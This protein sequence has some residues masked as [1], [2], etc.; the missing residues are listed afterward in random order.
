M[1]D[2]M[3]TYDASGNT[4]WDG[5]NYYWYDA[6]G[7]LCAVQSDRLN[8]LG[9]P[10]QYLYD[11]EGARIGKATLA[12]APA[13]GATCAPPQA[14][15]STLSFG[16]GSVFNTRWLV[17]LCGRQVTELTETPTTETWAHSNIFLG[18]AL[19][20]TYDYNNG[21]GGLHLTMLGSVWMEFS[22]V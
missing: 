19:A 5:N 14:S 17:D 21:K 13:I 9:T 6:E 2:W 22:Q 16:A 12:S 15:G 18:G 10:Y 20:A 7:Q 1:G 8:V 11:A 4:T 3:F